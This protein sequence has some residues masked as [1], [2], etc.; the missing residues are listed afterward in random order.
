MTA[1][2]HVGYN[3]RA[4][5]FQTSVRYHDITLGVEN[6]IAPED[7]VF[8]VNIVYTAVDIDI[9]V[10]ECLG[11]Q[12]ILLNY[13]TGVRVHQELGGSRFS[14]Y[15]DNVD[16]QRVTAFVARKDSELAAEWLCSFQDL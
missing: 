9:Q 15:A 10:I 13:L 2:Y 14:S 1:C 3:L 16:E 5:C 7:A 11:V 4:G 12:R 8:K 6:V